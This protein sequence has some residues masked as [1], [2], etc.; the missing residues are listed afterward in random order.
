MKWFD[1][2]GYKHDQKREEVHR[3]SEVSREHEG[4]ERWVVQVPFVQK[5][6][7]ARGVHRQCLKDVAV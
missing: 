3:M 6:L 5:R 2:G 1:M 7:Y 4:T